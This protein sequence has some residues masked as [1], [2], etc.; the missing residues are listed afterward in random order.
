MSRIVSVWLRSWPIAR[1][2]RAQ[3][4]AAPAEAIDWRRP[5]ALVAPGKGGARIVSLNRAARAG[6]LAE[7]ELVSNARSK[8]L[9][10]TCRDADPAADAAAL[11]RLALWCLRYCPVVAP[12]DAASGADGLFLDITGCAHL[13]GG[14][15]ELLADLGR[16]L[17]AFGLY[18]RTAIAGTAGAAWALA[19]HG[20]RGGTIVPS[21]GEERA[22]DRLPLAALRLSE[23]SQT[24]MRRLG[25]K[26]IGEL[27]RQPRAPFATR[28]PPEL[29]LRLDQALGRAPEPLVPVVPPPVYHAQASFL[30][31][32]LS[33]EHV[34]E[35]ATRL[36]RRLAEDLEAAAAGARVLRLMLFSVDGG[37]QSLDIGLAAPSRDPEHIAQLIGLRLYRLENGLEADFGFEAAAIHVLVAE[38]L[39]ARQDRLGMGEAAVPPEALARLIDRLQQRLGT[40]AVRQLHP[41]QSHTPERAVRAAPPSPRSRGE[42]RGEGQPGPPPPPGGGRACP[43]LD[44][45]TER[46]GLGSPIANLDATAGRRAKSDGVPGGGA[47]P[48]PRSTPPPDAPNELAPQGASGFTGRRKQAALTRGAS[49][50]PLEGEEERAAWAE[51]AAAPRPLLMLP[52]PEAAEVVA[53]IPEGPPRQFRWRGVLH[54]VAEAQG[55]ER[56][57]P[58]WWRRTGEPTRDY[59]VVEDSSGR[60]FWLYRA[61]LYGRDEA[62]PRW[63]VHGVF[64]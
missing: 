40:G 31:P 5:L 52:R 47:G 42:G 58:E 24:L 23:A 39:A 63:F 64:A 38:S 2:L 56:I 60:R 48:R 30:E 41:R 25:F 50:S 28:F 29:L 44:P 53:L 15:A 8:V 6:G 14:E 18:P 54:Q 61:G 35:A 51:G 3:A 59:Y 33:V 43:G 4:C 20:E 13:F 22:L 27:A 19:R 26:R 10:L 16:R 11:G 55:P 9:N 57:A 12:W 32:I 62:T 21:G 7:G 34:L 49:S 45:E 1:V 46:H 36:L 37:V 17:R